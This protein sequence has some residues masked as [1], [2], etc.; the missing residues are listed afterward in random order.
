MFPQDTLFIV[1]AGASAEFGFP[2]GDEF[3]QALA[4]KINFYFDE[5]SKLKRGDYQIIQ[6]LNKHIQNSQSDSHYRYNLNSFMEAARNIEDA[7]GVVTSIDSYVENHNGDERIELVSKLAIVQTILEAE[8]NS[9]L[10]IDISNKNSF[11]MLRLSN[12][13]LAK[14]TGILVN[15]VHKDK[16][17]DVFEN[18]SFISFNYDRCIEQ[19]LALAIKNV[20]SLDEA[21]AQRLVEEKLSVYHPYGKVGGMPWSKGNIYDVTFGKEINS[22][23]LLDQAKQIK[24]YSE[25]LKD[26]NMMEQIREKVEDASLIVFLGMAYHDQNLS[27]IRLSGQSFATR[28]YGTAFGMSDSDV[29]VINSLIRRTLGYSD[30]DSEL[31]VEIKN[32]LKASQ[33][34][35]EYSKSLSERQILRL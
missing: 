27:L 9:K 15:G 6:A 20:F 35:A 34:F 18:I 7:L 25:Q 22:S 21:T 23:V 8:R 17:E 19:Y 33:L 11:S 13:Y 4:N 26:I 29:K 32:S 3:K 24:T 12:T 1:G 30:V 28:V 5:P 2:Q 10:Y 16:I 14:L 31:T